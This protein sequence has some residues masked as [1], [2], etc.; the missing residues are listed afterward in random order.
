MN[1]YY[2]RIHNISRKI[3]IYPDLERSK[4]ILNYKMHMVNELTNRKLGIHK[5]GIHRPHIYHNLSYKEL[6]NHE[7]KNNEGKL[8]NTKYGYTY[9]VDTGI[10]TG[11]SPK[12]KWIVKN[13][14][15]ENNIHWGN[16]NQA[17]NGE[18]FSDLYDQ[19]IF[20]LSLIADD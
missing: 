13:I 9:S 2:N 5:L 4:S 6:L 17:I 15:S 12:D 14:E 16:N 20:Q 1:R 10:F 3:S 19:A 18:V 11:R 7:I 8:L